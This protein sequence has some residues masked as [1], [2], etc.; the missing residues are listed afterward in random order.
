MATRT[1]L[2]SALH[3]PSLDRSP[4]R[5]FRVDPGRPICPEGI[6]LDALT[7]ASRSRKPSCPEH[8]S[9]TS[10]S[11]GRASRCQREGRQ[12]ES[13]LVLHLRG[14]P[15][16]RV[17][18]VSS[19]W[20][21]ANFQPGPSGLRARQLEGE[22]RPNREQR[23]ERTG[24]RLAHPWPR[25]DASSN[26]VSCSSDENP[27]RSRERGSFVSRPVSAIAVGRAPRGSGAHVGN[28][29]VNLRGELR[30]IS[31]QRVRAMSEQRVGSVAPSE[32][33][34]AESPDRRGA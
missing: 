10:S 16:H 28:V 22:L 21:K 11:V 32:L 1:G 25:P 13:G 34:V 33:H 12:F 3:G 20:G 30:T 18:R 26:L 31:E 27:V 17:G 23:V 24:M 5:C 29:L 6:P 7:R 19:Y 9:R 15:S 4:K 2:T 14:N 8:I